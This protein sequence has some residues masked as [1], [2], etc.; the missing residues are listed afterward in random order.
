MKEEHVFLGAT[1]VSL[2]AALWML[3]PYADALLWAV[4]TAY[5]LHYFA[6]RLDEYVQNRA[7]STGV[8]LFLLI[9]FV[10]SMFYVVLTSIPQIVDVFSQFS[11]VLAGTVQV[12]IEV[13]NLPPS[14]SSSL[15]NVIGEFTAE[16][17]A[18]TVSQL[19]GIPGLVM[20]LLIYFVVSV[21]LVMEGKKFRNS[22]FDVLG[23]L[24]EYYRNLAVT[25]IESVDRLFRGVF[26]SYMVVAIA[27]GALA[28]AGFYLM[29]L[30]F[31]WGW[32]L[33]IG[34]FAF[35]PIVSAPMVYA[36]LALLY[37]AL[38]EFWL[39]VLILSYGIVVLNTLPEVV[40]RPY[41][42]AHHT[43]EHPLLLFIGFIIGSLTLGLK[44]VILGPIILIIAKDMLSMKYV[45]E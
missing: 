16:A 28:T 35:S 10:A 22:L 17:R 18:W 14:I 43:E 29:G 1:A 9:G 27:V 30:D 21:F 44:G 33:I 41:M 7:I 4:F 26:I 40:L 25:L 39:G 15:Q 11:E 12:M 38:G 32:G 13:F 24:P 8:V 3:W 5:F 23:E 42:A 31:Y 45:N 6:D 2:L 34:I 37:I 20:N 36:P 19:S